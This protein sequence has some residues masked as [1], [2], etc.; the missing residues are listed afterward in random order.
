MA[1]AGKLTDREQIVDALK[2]AH[3]IISIAARSLGVS[4]RSL[5]LAIHRHGIRKER[6]PRAIMSRLLS[7]A[8]QRGGRPRKSAA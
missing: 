1:A 5:K 2:D 6:T 3:W 7:E 8:G 4:R